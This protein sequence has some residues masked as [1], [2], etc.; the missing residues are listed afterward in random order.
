MDSANSLDRESL[1]Q[2]N[3]NTCLCAGAGSG[4]TSALVKMYLSLIAGDTSF[5]E[6]VRIEQ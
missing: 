3:E 1:F 6:P 2:F 5:G 4:K